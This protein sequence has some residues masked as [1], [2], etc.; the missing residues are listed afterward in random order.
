MH[1]RFTLVIPAAGK[2]SRL[3]YSLPKILF[4][5]KGQTPLEILL[6]LFEPYVDRTLL[7][8]SPDGKGPIAA[9]LKKLQRE[10]TLIEQPLPIGMVDAILRASPFLSDNDNVIVVWGDQVLL[11]N[12][13]IQ[14]AMQVYLS[15]PTEWPFAVLP[16]TQSKSPYV[17]FERNQTGQIAYCRLRR[18][19]DEMPSIGESDCGL[20]LLKGL[21]LRELLGHF[22]KSASQKGKIT[23]EISFPP[24]FPYLIRNGIPVVSSTVENSLEALGLND[25]DDLQRIEK[26]LSQ[27]R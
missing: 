25:K 22:S 11:S 21:L 20:F 8:V 12:R 9:E 13:T 27:T 1:N 5:L 15:Q 17:H 18:E 24:F 14:N 7:I 2:G 10:A 4:P 6:K 23:G 19:K 3:G 26:L 16:T